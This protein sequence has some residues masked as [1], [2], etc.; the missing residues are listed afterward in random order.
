MNLATLC[1]NIMK[2]NLKDGSPPREE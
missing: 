1:L 2:H